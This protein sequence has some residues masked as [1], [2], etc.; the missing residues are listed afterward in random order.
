MLEQTASLDDC[1]EELTRAMECARRKIEHMREKEDDDIILSAWSTDDEGDQPDRS[2]VAMVPTKPS[3]LT[4]LESMGFHD[5]TLNEKL[6]KRMKGNI[7]AVIEK[8]LGMVSRES[9]ESR[10]LSIS[11]ERA[12]TGPSSSTSKPSNSSAGLE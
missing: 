3:N 7:D 11:S 9:D 2:V 4:I 10:S 6:L 12:S 5:T 8:L 1:I